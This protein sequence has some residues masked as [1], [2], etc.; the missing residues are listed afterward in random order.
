MKPWNYDLLYNGSGPDGTAVEEVVSSNLTMSTNVSAT[1][2]LIE[3]D[4][5]DYCVG[6]SGGLKWSSTLDPLAFTGRVH[7][8][9]QV[10]A[11]LYV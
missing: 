7:R 1:A 11:P 8:L 3:T 4:G 2:D 10:V 6:V 9:P 5:Y